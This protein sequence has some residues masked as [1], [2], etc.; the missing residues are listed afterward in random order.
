MKKMTELPES[1][2]GRVHSGLRQYIQA[3]ES[4]FGENLIS[5]ILYGSAARDDHVKGIS[6]LNILILLNDAR[7]RNV[8]KAASIC[9]NARDKYA[10]ESRFMSL[11]TIQSASDVLPMAFLDMQEEYKVLYGKD[12]LKGIA[13]NHE[14]LRMQ[15][16]YQLR[17]SMMNLRHFYLFSSGNH[18]RMQ[19]VLVRSFTSFLHL[20]K[21]LFRLLGEK[22]PL[23]KNEIVD[24]SV[25]RFSLDRQVMEDLLALKMNQRRFRQNQ[26]ITLFEAYIDLL[27][28]LIQYVDKLPA[29]AE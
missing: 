3:L 11:D 22:P 8:K 18:K 12:L 10:V 27:Y 17:Y 28:G 5:V 23:H 15:C 9:R 4:L 16:E 20:L 24:L 21:S 26:L 25:D 1:L 13:I 6:D 19:S 14:N 2:P 7:I 29:G